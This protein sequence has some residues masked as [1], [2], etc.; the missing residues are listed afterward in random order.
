MELERRVR[1]WRGEYLRRAFCDGAV[2]IFGG[3]LAAA[4]GLAWA[5]RAFALPQGLRW[6]A[7]AAGALAFIWGIYRFWAAPAIDFRWEAV[8]S[9]AVRRHPS[10]GDYLRSA[11]ELRQAQAASHTSDELR[12]AHLE[13]TE[14][15]L[16][17]VPEAPLFSL[18]LTRGALSCAAAAALAGASLP[19]LS[20]SP[21]WERVL[22]PWRDVP[23]ERYLDIEP[24][25]AQTAWGEDVALNVRWRAAAP[26]GRDRLQLSLRLE[27]P[28]G[29]RPARWDR[30]NET[31][32]SF[33]A[34]GLSAPLRYRLVWR[35]LQS[36][37]YRLS[38]VSLPELESLRARVHGPDPSVAALTAA[39][40]L[41][42]LRGTMVTLS[43]KPNQVLAGAWM[44]LSTL[45]SPV[46][47]KASPSG[48]FEASL[49]VSE[50]AI[51]RFEL[52]TPDGRRA[53]SSAAYALKAVP[54]Q[55]P[56]IELLSPVEPLAASPQDSIPVAYQASDD[57]GLARISL[58]V[59]A[60]GLPQREIALERPGAKREVGGEYSWDL[61]GLP[62]G[63]LEF[64]LKAV[65]NGS[66]PQA[67][68]SAVGVI[69]LADFAA[70]HAETQA[71]W[72]KAE[73][74]LK[75]L[76][77]RE[78]AARQ[79]LAQG[80]LAER[81]LAELPKAWND[82]AADFSAWRK[83][84]DADPYAN[85]G[86]SQ[87][88]RTQAEGLEQAA[89]RDLPEA[90]RAGKAGDAALAQKK[91][92]QLAARA[93][94]AL[95]LLSEG[96]K[97]QGLQDFYAEAGRMSQ[98]GS[99]LESQLDALSRRG[100][101]G[102]DKEA[103]EKLKTGLD[104]LQRQMDALQKTLA[105]LPTVDPKSAESQS[106]KTYELP[107][108]AAR[109]QADALSRALAKG[110]Y[111][112]AAEIA[113]RLSESLAQMQ[114]ALG[115][116][117]SDAAGSGQPHQASERLAKAQA[118][119]AQA[120]EEQTKVLEQTRSL[121]QKRVEQKLAAQKDLLAELARRQEV[122][123]SSAA[124]LGDAFP[125]DALSMMRAVQKE[126]G[127]RKVEHS[128]AWLRGAAARL[129]IESSNRWEAQAAEE[130][131]IRDKLENGAELS[132]EQPSADSRA[133][134]QAQA[135]VR[136]R[137][138][139]LQQQLES[140]DADTG[141]LPREA[142]EKVEGAQ[143]EQAAAEDGLNKGQSASARGHEESALSM[144][145]AGAEAMS[146]AMS[147][148]QAAQLGLTQP[149]S[150]PNGAFRMMPGGGD[151]A[152]LGFVPLPSAKDYAPPKELRE[153]LKKSLQESRPPAYDPIIKEY[154]KRISQ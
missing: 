5:D 94:Q 6:A 86:L 143:G 50:D 121:E 142:L 12:R 114:R 103:L 91:H 42:V 7:L 80:A 16:R 39:E 23:L 126:L 53:V 9:A 51:L 153:E 45:P 66:P 74:S 33:T 70:G 110:D 26:P 52:E 75:S 27:G 119:W 154:F 131:A 15:L 32:A 56:K 145:N 65:D 93:R 1:I 24:G 77:E 83:A 69:E 29:W 63:K 150:R 46:A 129:R 135:Q 59:R 98:A 18:R 41:S 81:E 13:R 90:L 49:V 68:L 48:E 62:F 38:P 116:A 134:G 11:W 8:F 151:G 141:G 36:R 152:R 100:A 31:E 105:S 106:R 57:G 25:D 20:G 107:L 14:T 71:Q 85:P 140:I 73:Q 60:R 19:R 92:A 35:D 111:A 149:F 146:Q 113:R 67:G 34:E 47:M 130:D 72:A 104:K 64:Q 115:Q 102:A 139:Q 99:D 44:R 84:M 128:T 148:A 61:S 55:P 40:P 112:A 3:A 10:L 87:A 89:K 4:A 2:R 120:V 96:R 37:V 22:A 144:L 124:G 54:D 82:A 97:L 133:A 125:A 17:D 76:A 108:Q 95:Q 117:A 43:G 101:S 58:L 109:E 118:L 21:S 28:D 122:L 136:G 138:R 147:G 123:V 88:A 132:A 79:K 127:A 30:V 78:D 137:T